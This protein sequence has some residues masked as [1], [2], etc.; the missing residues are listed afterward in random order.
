MA[1]VGEFRAAKGRTGRCRSSFGGRESGEA[2]CAVPPPIL[3]CSGVA[4][5]L[6]PMRRAQ[7]SMPQLSG[8]V[9]DYLEFLPLLSEILYWERHQLHQ[10]QASEWSQ[11]WWGAYALPGCCP[12]EPSP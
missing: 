10:L 4:E 8:K 3:L 2:A 5:G 9:W 6:S 7:P 12:E 11:P 1:G